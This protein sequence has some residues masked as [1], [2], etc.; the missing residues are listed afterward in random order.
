MLALQT[1][2]PSVSVIPTWVSSSGEAR[3]LRKHTLSDFDLDQQCKKIRGFAMKACSLTDVS[4]TSMYT[5]YW[6]GISA[7]WSGIGLFSSHLCI[8]GKPFLE[9]QHRMAGF[10]KYWVF[11][12][13]IIPHC[14]FKEQSRWLSMALGFDS[15]FDPRQARTDSTRLYSLISVPNV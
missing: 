13:A 3:R 15:W 2:Q 4:I 7:L 11:Q 9:R 6:T 14:N 10:K 12:V 1:T 8:L 5:G